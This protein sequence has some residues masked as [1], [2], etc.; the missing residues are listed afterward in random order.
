M[1]LLEEPWGFPP[2]SEGRSLGHSLGNLTGLIPTQVALERAP[3]WS[4]AFLTPSAGDSV[5]QGMEA[6]P[7]DLKGGFSTLT[8]SH[9][10]ERSASL[11]CLGEGADGGS[12]KAKTKP[13]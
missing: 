5:P 3:V 2:I 13:D 11:C 10:Q 12:I 9:Q 4:P 1:G 6:S 7:L 8:S